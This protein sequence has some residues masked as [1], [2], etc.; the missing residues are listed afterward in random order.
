[1]KIY[2][3]EIAKENQ[4]KKTHSLIQQ[5]AIEYHDASTMLVSIKM[6]WKLG[7]EW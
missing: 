1:M 2:K 3:I 5:I 6:C 7:T 4:V